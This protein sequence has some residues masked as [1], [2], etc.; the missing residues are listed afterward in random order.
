MKLNPQLLRAAFAGALAGLLFGFDTG[1]VSGTTAGLTLRFSLTPRQL[2]V[3]V[4]IALWGAVL[5]AISA[6][7]IGQKLG[8]RATLRITAVLY[9]VSAI[10]SSLAVGWPMLLA[11]RFIGGLCI[12]AASVVGP[13]YIAEISPASWRGRMVGMFQINIVVGILI[14]YLSNYAVQS[15][16]LG[17]DEWR[18]QYGAAIAPALLFFFLLFGIPQ[19]PRWLATQNRPQEALAVL[20]RIGAA[21]PAAEM[22]EFA[23]AAQRAKSGDGERLF[24]R[25]YAFPI[26]LSVSIGALNQ[27]TGIN[28]IIY[29]LSG[30]FAGA[31]F[32]SMPGSVRGIVVGTVNM[33]ST[34][35]AMS[36]IDK[37][38]RKTLLLIGSVGTAAALAGV[39]LIFAKG[40]GR[41]FVLPLL[42]F[43]IFSFAISQG[44]VVW[45]YISEIFPSSVR[46][47]GQSLGCSANWVSNALVAVLFPVIAAH[48]ISLP[49]AFFTVV[50]C[51]Q[52]FIVLFVYPETKGIS[53]EALER[54]LG[55]SSL[56]EPATENS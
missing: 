39:T 50:A 38:G 12:G 27:L 34:F 32:G 16:H 13:V 48:S 51:A 22:Q 29:Y 21:D 7:V 41:Q 24:V 17:A 8:S 45:V 3:T 23:A 9:I 19:S 26:F 37:V 14:A 33:L 49:F 25:R 53:L 20:E 11:S 52:F 54:K 56:P 18:V 36:V 5:S 44:A 6:G 2:G 10:G 40:H 1:V 4:S 42:L 15:M 46:S 31:A 43:Y 28:A 55:L 35:V 47:K 30:I